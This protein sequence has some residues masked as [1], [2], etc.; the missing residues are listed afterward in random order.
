M[1]VLALSFFFCLILVSLPVTGQHAPDDGKFVGIWEL[2]IDTGEEYLYYFL[3]IEKSES[4]FKGWIG[5]EKEMTEGAPLSEIQLDG[6][7]LNFEFTAPTPPDGLE[8]LVKCE[9]K[10]SDNKLEGFFI[11]EDIDVVV[12]VTATKIS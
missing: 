12:S 3:K 1:Q 4:E 9:F 6:E 11:L 8:R 10:L 7:N 5:E 2:E